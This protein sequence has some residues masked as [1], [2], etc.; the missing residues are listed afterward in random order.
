GGRKCDAGALPARRS[1]AL[2][3]LLPGLRPC[4]SPA[5]VTRRRP[6]GHG[7]RRSPGA[8]R[9]CP[10][11][12][13]PRRAELETAPPRLRDPS[14][15]PRGR[16]PAAPVSH[17]PAL[18]GAGRSVLVV[19][20]EDVLAFRGVDVELGDRIPGRALTREDRAGIPRILRQGVLHDVVARLI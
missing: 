3:G 15:R 5:G 9:A 2:R 6:G 8:D 10:E 18:R 16:R 1:Q 7:A 4:L 20:V 11:A 14:R 12:P 19:P 17:L 13:L